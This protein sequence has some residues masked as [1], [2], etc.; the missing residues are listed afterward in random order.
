M[1]SHLNFH[2]SDCVNDTGSFHVFYIARSWSIV[3]VTCQ[4]LMS[5]HKTQDLQKQLQ[6]NLPWTRPD[7]QSHQESMVQLC[8][9]MNHEGKCCNPAAWVHYWSRECTRVQAPPDALLSRCNKTANQHESINMA[10]A[11]G[12][13]TPQCPLRFTGDRASSSSSPK[14]VAARTGAGSRHLSPHP[15]LG[16]E[17]PAA[18]AQSGLEHAPVSK[19]YR[20]KRLDQPDMHAPASN[21]QALQHAPAEHA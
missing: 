18:R 20:W 21:R 7:T 1:S 6:D 2:L 5:Q 14:V 11:C 16:R 13:G 4:M 9:T 19:H 17:A 15:T 10:C 3:N 8:G 12:T